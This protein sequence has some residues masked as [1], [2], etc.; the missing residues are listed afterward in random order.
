M[1]P[2]SLGNFYF[3]HVMI[4]SVDSIVYVY[5]G[6]KSALGFF[7]STDNSEFA[8]Q[9]AG[10]ALSMIETSIGKKI[11][12]TRFILYS[13]SNAHIR[14]YCWSVYCNTGCLSQRHFSYT[15]DEFLI[16]LYLF[17]VLSDIFYLF[18]LHLSLYIIYL[19]ICMSNLF[20]HFLFAI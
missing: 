6:L 12:R 1:V 15:I 19:V 7:G 16:A 10:F 18:I 9:G 8:N 11:I 5:L 13:F 3:V 2:G 4:S 14:Y 17:S 20:T